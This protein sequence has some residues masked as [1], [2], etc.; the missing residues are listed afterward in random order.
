M[1]GEA[2]EYIREAAGNPDQSPYGMVINDE[3]PEDEVHVMIIAAGFERRSELKIEEPPRIEEDKVLPIFGSDF[4]N[5]EDDGSSKLVIEKEEGSSVPQEQREIS[6]E[7][8]SQE[9]K[10]SLWLNSEFTSPTPPDDFELPT[11][12]RRKKG[13][14]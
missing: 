2:A 5:E 10:K 8:K 9:S 6:A 3:L 7:G 14:N 4:D 11:Y 13:D 1:I 12:I